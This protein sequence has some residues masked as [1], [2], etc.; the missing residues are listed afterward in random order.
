MSENNQNNHPAQGGEKKEQSNGERAGRNHRHRRP[1]HRGPRPQQNAEQKNAE[2]KVEGAVAAPN[3][4]KKETRADESARKQPNQ[5]R[6]GQGNRHG[7]GQNN[8][9]DKSRGGKGNRHVLEK[10]PFDPYEQPSRQE[11]ELSELRD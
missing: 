7:R 3:T 4:E 11:I 9:K 8:H 10:R 2:Q 6:G 1:H 5:S